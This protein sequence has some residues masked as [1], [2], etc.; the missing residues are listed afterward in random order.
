[1]TEQRRNPDLT[2]ARIDQPRGDGMGR[3][4]VVESRLWQVSVLLDDPG[5]V[6]ELIDE[7]RSALEWLEEPPT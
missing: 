4:L 1:V 2:V 3:A 7:L 6:Q 5:D